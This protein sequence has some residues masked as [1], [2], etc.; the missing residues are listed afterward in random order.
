MGAAA[1]GSQRSGTSWDLKFA[2]FDASGRVLTP[3]VTVFSGMFA[4]PT[5]IRIGWDGSAWAIFYSEGSGMRVVRVADDGTTMAG[6]TPS[7]SGQATFIMVAQ[8]V[9]EMAIAWDRGSSELNANIYRNGSTMSGNLRLQTTSAPAVVRRPAMVHVGAGR[10]VA[11]LQNGTQ[12][13]VQPFRPAMMETSGSILVDAAIEV[14]VGAT[15]DFTNRRIGFVYQSGS[16]Q[17]LHID[18]DT[19]TVTTT[20]R[21][22]G[23]SAAP[24]V[25]F[26]NDGSFLATVNAASVTPTRVRVTDGTVY[27]GSVPTLVGAPVDVTGLAPSTNRYLVL[28][29]MGGNL[30]TQ[31][32]TC[33]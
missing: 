4:L 16:A 1:W 7:A 8:G 10:Y 23:S 31:V 29:P 15:Y 32:L 27:P 25:A 14:P 6:S 2:R 11:L 28:V 18:P 30:M 19:M 9:D 13:T 24:A 12:V 17:L 33:R 22:L 5:S 20:P 21:A 26:G 3:E